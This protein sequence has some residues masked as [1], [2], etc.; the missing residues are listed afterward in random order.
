MSVTANYGWD[1]PEDREQLLELLLRQII[2]DID[3]DVAAAAAVKAARVTN[4]A[5][6]SVPNATAT[7]LTFDQERRD[8]GSLHSTSSNTDRLTAP[9]AG[10]YQIA[11]NVEFATNATGFRTISVRKNGGT[12]IIWVSQANAVSGTQTILQVGCVAYLAA[13]DYVSLYAYQSSG[14]ALNV[15]KSDEYSPEFSMVLVRRV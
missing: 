2:I 12:T 13:N 9:V 1:L 3:A 7:V 10:W 15:Q 4:S 5:A 11:G 6:I 8:D 14:G